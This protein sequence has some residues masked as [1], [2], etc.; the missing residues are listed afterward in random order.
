MIWNIVIIVA[1]VIVF[2]ILARRIPLARSFQKK[3]EPEISNEEMTNFG[4]M[5]KADE[6]FSENNF[7]EAEKWYV[8]AAATAPNNAKI[9]GRLGAIYLEQK[10]YYD[11]KEAFLVAVKLDSKKP[12]PHINLGLAYLG[13]KDYFKAE[14]TFAAALKMDP[15]NKTKRGVTILAVLKV[16]IDSVK[17]TIEAI[18][19]HFFSCIPDKNNQMP[20]T[21]KNVATFASNAAL[22]NIICQ[23]E[24]ARNNAESK[25]YN[26]FDFEFQKILFVKK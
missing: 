22:D 14:K 2:I 21:I 1:L 8:K 13:L 11:A 18:M 3:E 12:S 4:M 6:A 5:N 10:N 17:E 16:Y 25:A 26:S 23:G 15:K 19:Y 7:V 24:I 9:Y 20:P